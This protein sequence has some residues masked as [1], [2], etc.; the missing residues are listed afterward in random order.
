MPQ[1]TDEQR[2]RWPGWD[3]EAIKFLE[4]AGYKLTRDWE[5][6]KPV[7]HTPT[8]RELDAIDYMCNEWDFG[9][10]QTQVYIRPRQVP[11]RFLP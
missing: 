2:A 3:A 6:I 10:I 11:T 5:W 8:E 7:G 4:D 9:G 1:A